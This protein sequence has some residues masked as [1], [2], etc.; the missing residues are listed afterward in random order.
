MTY[1]RAMTAG[2]PWRHILRFA[3]PVLAGSLLQ[4]LYSLV[5]Q[6][7]VGNFAGQDALAAIGTT[8]TFTLFFLAL[9]IGFSAGSGVLVSQFYGAQD[10]AN[11]RSA[12]SVGVLLLLGFGAVST[13][14][15]ILV[16]RPAFDYFVDAP[17]E[18]LDLTV[19]YF[20]VYMYGLIFQFGFNIFA[21]NLRAVG[22]S[23]STLYFLVVSS[24]VN[25][26]LDLLFVGQFRWGVVG[27][28]AATDVA[29]AV[30]CAVAYVYMIRRYP[31]FHIRLR[32]YR[33]DWRVAQR[34][35]ELGFPIALHMVVI[36]VGTTVI[37]RA[38]NGYGKIMTASFAVGR[39]LELFLNFP[40]HAL[41][42]TL[43]TFTG[44]NVGAKRLDRVKLGG[45][46]TTVISITFTVFISI[47]LWIFA[48]QIVNFFGLDAEAGGYCT[49]H[50]RA[51]TVINIV[52]CSYL[53]LFGLFQGMRKRQRTL[54]I[55]T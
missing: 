26:V 30:S 22:D 41:Q 17:D 51:I 4:H 44:Q 11:V 34:I 1:G 6:I 16:A 53:P 37:Q 28:A 9:A 50:V 5:D 7:I 19:K 12:S 23:A 42:T 2:A 39:Q 32:E 29:Q 36:A 3:F 54:I 49:R 25:I 8:V 18:I 38:V 33:W 27:A 20:T 48:P 45:R 24:I 40:S 13:G 21:A 31:I 14:V 52:L 43:A 15:G 10:D 35:V 46:Q 55:R 47:F